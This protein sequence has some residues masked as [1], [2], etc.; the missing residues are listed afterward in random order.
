MVSIGRVVR[1]DTS[2]GD[3]RG[4]GG[5]VFAP[6]VAKICGSVRQPS[7]IS[8]KQDVITARAGSPR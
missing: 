6:R 7:R 5:E 8:A 1:W 2:G 3:A 4:V